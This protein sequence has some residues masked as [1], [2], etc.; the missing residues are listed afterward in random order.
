[1]LIFLIG[2]IVTSCKK[3]P[4][5]DVATY[6][7]VYS[8]NNDAFYDTPSVLDHSDEYKIILPKRGKVKLLKNGEQIEKI[9]A[10]DFRYVKSDENEIMIDT[11]PFELQRS[12]KSFFINEK[13][14]CLKA[15]SLIG[16]Y[17]G[18]FRSNRF[19]EDTTLNMVVE[20][21]EVSFE[22]GCFIKTDLDTFHLYVSESGKIRYPFRSSYAT[23]KIIGDS[24]I[25]RR[26]WS[27][28]YGQYGNP[29]VNS[30]FRG[31]RID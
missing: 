13:S 15:E 23:M 4:E 16:E 26:C 14:D 24:L 5:E 18:V 27:C 28:G 22:N 29:Y 31:K 10:I 25:Y 9:K 30:T 20:V 21:S 8:Y 7:W 19:D 11:L 17:E 2:L 6:T 3:Y 12:M 1:M